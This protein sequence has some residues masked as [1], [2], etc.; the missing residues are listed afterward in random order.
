M[1]VSDYK[2]NSPHKNSNKTEIKKT[3]GVPGGQGG[4]YE[5]HKVGESQLCMSLGNKT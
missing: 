5:Q 3:V 4:G 2:N 1:D